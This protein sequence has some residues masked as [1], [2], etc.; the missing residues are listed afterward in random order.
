MIPPIQQASRKTIT[1][2]AVALLASTSM[3]IQSTYAGPAATERVSISSEGQEGNLESVSPSVDASGRF[4]VFASKAS[5]LVPDDSNNM[6]DIFL[7]DW[8]NGTTER[9]SIAY[10]GSEPNGESFNPAIS[11]DGNF[12]TFSS[13]ASNLVK[14]DG[15]NAQDVF[16]YDRINATTELISITASHGQANGPSYEPSIS[17]DGRYI[18]YASEATNIYEGATA[19][20]MEVYCFDRVDRTLSWVSG[21]TGSSAEGKSSHQPS[22]SENG[23]WVAFSS[24]K[25]D[26][27]SGDKNNWPDVF[28]WD[29]NSG[30]VELVSRTYLGGV[31]PFGGF[32]PSVSGDGHYVVFVSN[33]SSIV[34]D[35]SNGMLDVFLRDRSAG[36]VERVNLSTSGEEAVGGPSFE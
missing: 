14:S 13:T 23:R 6:Q 34:P 28:I 29:R 32:H 4:I 11:S 36:T 3:L 21:P 16:L 22:I 7:H 1:V 17:G 12:I 27:V 18:A 31:S 19:E 5:S 2:F 10:D 26:L 25:P 24:D 35:D 33:S 15:N 8:A 30:D 9:I 20:A